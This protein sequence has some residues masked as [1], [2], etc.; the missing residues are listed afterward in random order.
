VIKFNKQHSYPVLSRAEDEN[1]NRLYQTP[2]GPLPSVTTILSETGDKTGLIEWER[3]IGSEMAEKERKE[4]A[5]L[6]SIMHTHLENYLLGEQRPGGSNLIYKM[7]SRMADVIIE[8]GLSQ[9]DEVWGMEE[10]LYYPHLY[11]GTADLIGIFEGKPSIIDFKST[12]KPKKEKW[13][14]NYFLQGAA[15]ALAHN[16]LFDTNIEQIVILMC[17]R[18]MEFQKFIITPESFPK[19]SKLWVE[20]LKLFN[21]TMS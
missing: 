17:S 13:I 18:E 6:G 5:G 21:A 12:K 10:C 15:Y 19:Y 2:T 1:G 3:R 11:A 4:A 7:A 8:C 14:E 16:E 9:M 20:R